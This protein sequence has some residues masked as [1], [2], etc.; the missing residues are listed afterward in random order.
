MRL[1]IVGSGYVG[2]VSGACLAEL[3]HAV[4]C[5]D[6][7]AEK[8]ARLRSGDIPI[9]EPKLAG[10][11]ARNVESQRLT[12]ADCL[13]EFGAEVENFPLQRWPKP[14]VECIGTQLYWILVAMRAL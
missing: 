13:P 6:S 9:F 8:I 4:L 11:I 2:L 3:G 1:I 14:P 5:I 7:D 10:M 12:Y